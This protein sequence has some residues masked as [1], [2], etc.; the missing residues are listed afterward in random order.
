MDM[1][2]YLGSGHISRIAAASCILGEALHDPVDTLG[3]QEF[4][5]EVGETVKLVYIDK[6]PQQGVKQFKNQYSGSTS[7]A[8]YVYFII[9]FLPFAKAFILF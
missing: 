4:G 5:I 2:I 8:R 9:I 1:F 7:H 3:K 6:D